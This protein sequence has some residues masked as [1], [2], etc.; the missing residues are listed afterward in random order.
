MIDKAQ[1]G[2]YGLVHAVHELYGPDVAGTLLSV[3]SRLFTSFLQVHSPKLFHCSFSILFF[4]NLRHKKC[5]FCF[6]MHGF[7]CGVDDL[8][9]KRSSDMERDRILE[10]SEM[11]SEEVHRRFT[12]MKDGDKGVCYKSF[13]VLFA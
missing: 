11:L 8:L 7:T 4:F 10:K 1:F 12:R 13:S 3:F 9:L 5:L 6:Q 2:T